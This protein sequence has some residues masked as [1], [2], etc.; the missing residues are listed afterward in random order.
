MYLATDG[1]ALLPVPRTPY[2]HSDA[3]APGAARASPPPRWYDAESTSVE[4]CAR[5]ARMS[6]GAA[7]RAHITTYLA[8]EV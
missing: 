5:R 8:R 7:R 3:A 6:R 2:A 4:G 1:G